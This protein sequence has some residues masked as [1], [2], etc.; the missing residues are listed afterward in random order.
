[1]QVYG[2]I[3]SMTKLKIITLKSVCKLCPTCLLIT[4]TFRIQNVKQS[5]KVMFKS[6][7]TLLNLLN[8]LTVQLKY[9]F[10]NLIMMDGP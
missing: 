8:I 10:Y 1:M 6:V 2:K 7:F 3:K 9:F 5:I 4:V